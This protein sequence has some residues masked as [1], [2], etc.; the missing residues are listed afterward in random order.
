[1]KATISQLKNKQSSGH[2]NISTNLLKQLQNSI[3][4]PL[5]ILINKSF[6]MGEFPDA[7]KIAK[8]IPI[9]KSNDQEN[10]ENYRS[11]AVLTSISKMFEKVLF[12][13]ILTFF[14]NNNILDDNQYGF[15]PN[16]CTID[17][18]MHFSEIVQ[19]S[20][21]NNHSS[22][23]LSSIYPRHLIPWTILYWKKSFTGME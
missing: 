13:R 11:I 14:E 20:M 23:G 10:I 8:V 7:L 21:E 18:I 6:S 4:K 12:K 5:T 16:R 19:E 3:S 17:A 1:M 15:R 2:D 9:F 22:V